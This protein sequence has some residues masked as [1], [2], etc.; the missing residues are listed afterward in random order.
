[1]VLMK[2]PYLIFL[3]GSGIGRQ[4]VRPAISFALYFLY[5]WHNPYFQL[6]P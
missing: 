2:G 5:K 3:S 6:H 1:M 4:E